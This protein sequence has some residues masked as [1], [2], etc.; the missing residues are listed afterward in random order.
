LTV[1]F[2]GNIMPVPRGNVTMADENTFRA[3]GAECLSGDGIC[4]T[5]SV[6]WKTQHFFPSRALTGFVRPLG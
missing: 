4:R 6:I 2:S 1:A 3:F 5:E